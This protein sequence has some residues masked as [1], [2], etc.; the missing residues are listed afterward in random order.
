M[1][2]PQINDILTLKQQQA[3]V[4]QAWESVKQGDE[5]VRQGRSIMFFTVFTI[6]FLPLSFMTSV[7][8]MNNS[9]FGDNQL[10]LRDEMKFICK[11]T[12]LYAIPISH[13][14]AI[15]QGADDCSHYL[16]RSKPV[17]TC[18]CALAAVPSGVRRGC[19]GA[20]QLAPHQNGALRLLVVQ[21]VELQGEAAAVGH[22]NQ[23]VQYEEGHQGREVGLGD[24]K[25]D[26][27][28][29]EKEGTAAEGAEEDEARGWRRGGI[30]YATASTDGWW[31]P[32]GWCCGARSSG[33][34]QCRCHGSRQTAAAAGWAKGGVTPPVIM[35]YQV[36]GDSEGRF[37][38][39]HR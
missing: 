29:Q 8:G 15:S 10:T 5:T 26:G 13:Y 20:L 35:G 25:V 21:K 24:A 11:A 14:C 36:H 38:D 1:K 27:R 31:A 23:S 19:E 6:L 3:S 28:K 22:G 9:D 7:F 39:K 18:H 16:G 2:P 32:I 17:G 30:K 33:L 37:G 12:P 34:W 4:V